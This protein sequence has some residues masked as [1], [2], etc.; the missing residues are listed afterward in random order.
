MGWQK[1]D[2]NVL[3]KDEQGNSVPIP[4]KNIAMIYPLKR[5]DFPSG[6]VDLDGLDW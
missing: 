4:G 6:D 5:K 1:I 2:A 3:M